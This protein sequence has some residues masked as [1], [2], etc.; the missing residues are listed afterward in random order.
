MSVFRFFSIHTALLT[1]ITISLSACPDPEDDDREAAE[2]ATDSSVD[3]EDGSTG[4]PTPSE[5]TGT[6][7]PGD[8]TGSA[9]EDSGSAG[10]SE[11]GGEI[12][13]A[14]LYECEE[15]ELMPAPFVGAAV[16]PA[17]GELTGLDQG[18][19]VVHTTQIL[20]RPDAT[21]QM[22]FGELANG[23][24]EQLMQTPGLKGFSFASEPNCGF[25]RTMGVWDSE[26]A[27]Y[28]FVTSGA[29]AVAMTRA[30]DVAVTARVTHWT[31]TSGTPTPTW[32]EA[33]ATIANVEPG[34]YR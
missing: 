5:S 32:E 29:H 26:A 9:V 34:T 20:V 33:I 31:A 27:M 1:S 6:A 21:S 4:L 15:T 2:D 19:Y 10:E 24:T 18:D 11:S 17:T 3:A 8:S 7:D 25:L 14:A 13:I 22:T 12:D 16:D 28:T 23:V 30:G